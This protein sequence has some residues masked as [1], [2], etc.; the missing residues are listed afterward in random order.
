[1]FRL[2]LALLSFFSFKA[3]AEF[4]W[5]AHR[6]GRG[7]FPENTILG[8]QESLKYP[9]TTLELDVVMSKDKQVVVS[10]EPWMNEEICLTPTGGPVRGREVNLYALTY[11]TIKEYD[12]GSKAHPRFPRQKNSKQF[13]P[14]LKDLLSELKASGKKFNIE[15]KSTEEDEKAGFQPSFQLFS[16]TVLSV[17]KGH[18]RPEQ[19][20]VQ[21][22]DW[23]VLRY[24]HEKS[25]EV[26]LVAL[27]ETAYSYQEIL[28]ELGFTPAVF[29]PNFELLTAADVAYFHRQKVKVIPWTVNTIDSMK[30]VIAMNVDGVITDYPDLIQDI[31]KDLYAVKPE[32]RSDYNRFEGECIKIPAHAEA[33][34]QNPGWVCKDGYVQKR[35]SCVKIN[36]PKS[37][38]LTEDGKT[39]VCKD[40]YERYRL[41]CRKILKK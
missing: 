32:C 36:I 6:G 17:I 23:R 22:F 30:R 5:Q 4:D 25:P 41:K 40:G 10:H 13:K 7:L 27:R 19:Y 37:A 11:K 8:M 12:C 28:K 9:I 26:S 15:I 20:T 14:L 38:V 24:L 33:S 3:R 29:S 31:P 16:D 21:S 1:M 39:W 2:L 18:L 35:L 34:E